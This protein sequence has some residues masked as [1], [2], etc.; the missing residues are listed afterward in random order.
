MVV[1]SEV[2]AK[3]FQNLSLLTEPSPKHALEATCALPTL[4]CS[5][6]G[7]RRLDAF[8]SRKSGFLLLMHRQFICIATRFGGLSIVEEVNLSLCYVI[9]C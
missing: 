7:M 4:T 3:Q 8:P 5:L 9:R 1:R 6:T 2:T